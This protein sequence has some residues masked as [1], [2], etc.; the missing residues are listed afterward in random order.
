MPTL[1]DDVSAVIVVFFMLWL[2][3]LVT[4]RRR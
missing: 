2:V 1:L 3:F 4:D